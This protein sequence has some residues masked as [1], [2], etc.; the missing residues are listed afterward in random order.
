MSFGFDV[1]ETM[2]NIRIILEKHTKNFVASPILI[3]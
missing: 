3:S 1:S 2:R